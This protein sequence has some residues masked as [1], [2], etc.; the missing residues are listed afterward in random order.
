[1]PPKCVSACRFKITI[2]RNPPWNTLLSHHEVAVAPVGRG[3]T[4]I[5]D[6]VSREAHASDSDARS[7]SSIYKGCSPPL[8]QKSKS[9]NDSTGF[10]SLI[11]SESITVFHGDRND[12]ENT[13]YTA[14]GSIQ[15]PSIS[16]QSKNS[17]QYQIS[18][19]ISNSSG[20]SRSSCI[21][22]QSSARSAEGQ[23]AVITS[24]VGHTDDTLHQASPSCTK[25]A[26]LDTS[27]EQGHNE[28][29][30]RDGGTVIDVISKGEISVAVK[31]GTL[32]NNLGL[33]IESVSDQ[34]IEENS[35]TSHTAE[36]IAHGNISSGNHHRNKFQK[37]RAKLNGAIQMAKLRDEIK[38]APTDEYGYHPECMQSTINEQT[39]SPESQS[40]NFDKLSRRTSNDSSIH[41]VAG[42]RSYDISRKANIRMNAITLKYDRISKALD[43]L[44]TTE[45]KGVEAPKYGEYKHSLASLWYKKGRSAI[46]R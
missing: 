35:M 1:M 36:D 11:S 16:D 44:A 12:L 29:C 5:K 14:S 4:T 30:N 8:Q 13:D 42:K 17:M 39:L 3:S 26:S 34:S 20:S 37:I 23:I 28:L 18:N 25:L 15:C 33:E 45:I 21:I 24:T 31:K 40:R 32:S 9:S 43:Q 19:A 10:K 22:S 38:R 2:G 6:I 46:S 41:R 7:E 27:D